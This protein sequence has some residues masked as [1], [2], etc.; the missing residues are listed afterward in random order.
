MVNCNGGLRYKET[1]K[2]ILEQSRHKSMLTIK[3]NQGVAIFVRL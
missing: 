1:D 3:N 2:L